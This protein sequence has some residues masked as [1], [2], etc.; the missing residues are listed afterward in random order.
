MPPRE[1]ERREPAPS[2]WQRIGIS[3]IAVVVAVI[4]SRLLLPGVDLGV[5]PSSADPGL[6]APSN[7]SVLA[8][9][10]LPIAYGYMLVEIAAVVVP[11]LEPLRHHPE[12]REKLT[13]VATWLTLVL[14]AVQAWMVAA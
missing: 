14:A 13:R 1:P 7:L 11:P 8:L 4:G 5:L 6:G 3:V 9:G 12:G 10:I 2:F